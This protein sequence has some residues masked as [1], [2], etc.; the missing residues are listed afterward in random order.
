MK[1]TPK[2]TAAQNVINQSRTNMTSA[3]PAENDSKAK[4]ELPRDH[5]WVEGESKTTCELCGK[6]YSPD[7]AT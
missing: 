3:T 2:A 6:D 7:D 5:W 4:C 1:I